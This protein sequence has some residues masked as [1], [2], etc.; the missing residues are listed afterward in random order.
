MEK[1]REATTTKKKKKQK[2]G[3]AEGW[4]RVEERKSKWKMA[5][6]YV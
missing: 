4:V 5:D 3:L 2:G 1:G 6:I